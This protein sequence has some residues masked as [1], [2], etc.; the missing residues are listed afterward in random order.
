MILLNPYSIPPAL[1][2]LAVIGLGIF[3]IIKNPRVRLNQI[4]ALLCLSTT[5]WL[6]FYTVSYNFNKSNWFVLQWYR[7]SYCGIAFIAITYFH[8]L[9]T[10]LKIHWAKRWAFFNYIYGIII[11]IFI[12]FTN[13]IVAGLYQF[14]WG[15]Y[16]KAGSWHPYFLFYFLLLIIISNILLLQKVIQNQTSSIEANQNKYVLS[17]LFIFSFASFDFIPNYGVKFYPFGYL[18]TTI[19]I[20]IITYAIVKHQLMD[21]NIVIRR[22][23]I[24]SLLITFI[25]I[26]YLV[27]VLLCEKV[28]QEFIG[29]RTVIGSII[30][31]IVIAV[32]F[33]P[34]KN[35]IQYF[36]D[37]LIFRG[38]QEEIVQQNELFRQEILRTEKLKAISTFASGMAHE[39]KNPLTAIKT[40]SE[41]LQS[42]KDDPEFLNKFS[43]IVNHEVDRINDLVCQLLE[44]AKPAA[45]TLKETNIHRLINSTLELLNSRFLQNKIK[46]IKIFSASLRQTLHIDPNQFRQALLNIF[47]NAIE[48]MPNGGTLRVET[49][50]QS[51]T[52]LFEITISDT[53]GG[54]APND[55]PHIF[56]PFFSKKDKGTGLGLSITH[57]IIKEHGGT[58]RVASTAK[59]GASFTIKVPAKSCPS[60]PTP[61][62]RGRPADETESLNSF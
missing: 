7:I 48:A 51:S 9:T 11:S 12:L 56:D 2:S 37:K 14:S 35:K 31:A 62:K 50:I 46:L 25:T 43:K 39:I 57:G 58:I 22:G 19:F 8:Y 40:F 30:A 52:P 47:L 18:P 6:S 28:F 5:V 26:T 1:S 45:L 55:L 29:Y 34:F 27:V 42:K 59:H 20:T 54:I 13:K 23:L 17:G 60:Q 4:F 15:S 32:F 10:F 53:G 21:I 44:F 49:R 33:A 38:S 41:H 36:I 3:V 16:P 61:P 24:Y